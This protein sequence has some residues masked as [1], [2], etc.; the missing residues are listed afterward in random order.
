MN[1]PPLT[2]TSLGSLLDFLLNGL[3]YPDEKIKSS[4]V[5]L[6]VQVAGKTP[7]TSLPLSLVQRLARH[8]ST[9]LATAKSHDLTINLL[10]EKMQ[11]L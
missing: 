5:Y 8:I 11:I 4:V 1:P 9:N 2:H 3:S 6:L 10:G 7:P